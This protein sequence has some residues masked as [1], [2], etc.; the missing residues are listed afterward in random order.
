MFF[1]NRRTVSLFTMRVNPS[2]LAGRGQPFTRALVK[3]VQL[4]F[5]ICCAKLITALRKV[6][7]ITAHA[8]CNL[9]APFPDV[10]GDF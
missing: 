1:K 4:R 8:E 5:I 3:G 9:V 10:R 7:F 2:L 6:I